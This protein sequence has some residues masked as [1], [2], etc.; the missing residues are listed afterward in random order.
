MQIKTVRVS[1]K[2]QIAI[3]QEIRKQM[4][5]ERGEELILLQIDGK[6]L[7]EKQQKVAKKVEDDFK[8]I[9]KFSEKSLKEVW[10]NKSDDIWSNYLRK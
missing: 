3:P 10:D 7:I 5:I 2:G 4:S 1:D 8:D 9:L 6:L